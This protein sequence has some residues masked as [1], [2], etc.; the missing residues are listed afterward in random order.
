MSHVTPLILSKECIVPYR[1]V[2]L[3]CLVMLPSLLLCH[4]MFKWKLK[5]FTSAVKT[6]SVSVLLS[7]SYGYLIHIIPKL[8]SEFHVVD[9]GFIMALLRRDYSFRHQ[10]II[11]E[12]VLETS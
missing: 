6:V 1:I 11:Q 2:S 4:L 10:L 8:C 12:L 3:F 5:K 7:Q 9:V